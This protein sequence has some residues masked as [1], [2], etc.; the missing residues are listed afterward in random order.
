MSSSRNSPGPKKA[1]PDASAGGD[2]AATNSDGEPF[3]LEGTNKTLPEPMP[4]AES[5]ES[6]YRAPGKHVS[7]TPYTR[8][9]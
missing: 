5:V 2:D 6:D 3:G 4:D 8:K 1:R 7:K 9:I